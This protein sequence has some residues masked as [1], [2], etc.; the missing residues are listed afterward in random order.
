MRVEA[1]AQ[2]ATKTSRRPRAAPQTVEIACDGRVAARPRDRAPAA[3]P[4]PRC[5][6]RTLPEL[7]PHQLDLLG[8]GLAALGVFLAFV[9]YLGAAGGSVGGAASDG[10]RLLLG[11]VAYAVPVALVAGGVLIVARTLVPA[12][13]PVRAGALCLFAGLALALAAGTLGLGSDTGDGLWA[14]HHARR[15]RRRRRR[16]ALLD[17]VAPLLRRR[18]AHHRDLPAARRAAADQR[19]DDRRRAAARSRDDAQRGDARAA[20]REPAAEPRRAPPHPSSRPSPTTSSSSS[21]PRTSR[22][23]RSTAASAT[24][25][26]T[27]TMRPPTRTRSAPTSTTSRSRT[28]DRRARGRRRGDR[29][30][31]A[32]GARGAGRHH[33]RRGRRPRRPD[34]AGPLPR[35]RHRR[36]VVRLENPDRP[37]P[38]ALDGR[39]VA[40]RHGRAGEDR[41][42]ADRGAR[43][44]RDRGEG[45]R[46]DGRPAHHALRDP[47]RAWHQ[48]RQSRAAEGRP[49]LR[50]RRD[51]DPHPRADPRQAGGRRRGPEREAA[52]RPPRRR[53]PGSAEGLVAAH[54]LA[55][56]GRRRPRDRR[57][58][59]ED[60]APA[61]RRHDRRRQVRLH[62]RDALQPAAARRPARA[63]ARAR[64]PQAGRAE[65]L[66]VD[67]APADARHH[68]P[69]DG[70]QRAPEPR[71]GDGGALRD[72]VARAHALAAGA[73]QSA[74]RAR[75]ARAAVHPVRDRRAGRPDDGRARRRRGLD[76]PPRAEGARGRHPPRARDAVA[77]AWT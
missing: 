17:D 49:R 32:G 73:Q 23:R 51:R 38:Q 37:L 58:P 71:Q 67:P 59:R 57:R 24:R 64:R 56:Q 39:P 46:H 30:A 19:R 6:G 72:H 33:R 26:C 61:R 68:E 11:Q 3:R 22:R 15:E 10:L 27:A 35:V 36:P 55:R 44:L 48:G 31:R 69:A 5:G 12:A 62:Q 1:S 8:L 34:A 41:R 52:D 45:R 53:L 43:P 40:P 20:S 29:A 74:R 7:S 2:M 76:H 77:R 16:H 63:A 65:P 42:A 9:L 28:P 47:P 13:Q 4:A 18:L 70:G 25:T 50:A 14:Q 60:A 54:R 66:R 21:A 75:R